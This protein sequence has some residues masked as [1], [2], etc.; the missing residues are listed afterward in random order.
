MANVAETTVTA[1]LLA[2]KLGEKGAPSDEAKRIY[3]LAVSEVAG[4]FAGAWKDVPVEI[5]DE[6]VYRVGRAIKDTTNKSASG[7]GQVA[8]N[9]GPQLRAPADPLASSYA[10]IRRYVVVGV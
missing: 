9:E 1:A 7:S 4:A 3:A 10:L 6:C 8:V 5:V 2:P